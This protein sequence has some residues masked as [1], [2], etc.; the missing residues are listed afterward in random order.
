M[1]AAVQ[2]IFGLIAV[3]MRSRRPERAALRAVLAHAREGRSLGI[4]VDGP[5]GPARDVR[6]AATDWAE[7][8]DRPIYGYAFATSRMRFLGTWDMQ[9]I[10]LPFARGY[11]IFRALPAG[12]DDLATRIA[13]HLDAL[14]QEADHRAAAA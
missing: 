14:T 3:E 8:L 11:V 2:R 10:P 5:R 13:H 9:A 4:A 1:G 6:A 12:E 7:R